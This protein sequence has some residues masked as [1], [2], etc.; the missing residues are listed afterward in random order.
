MLAAATSLRDLNITMFQERPCDLEPEDM[1]LLGG[2]PHLTKLRLG[3][4]D[5]AMPSSMQ[6]WLRALR[7][8]LPQLTVE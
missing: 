3:L 6:R 5:P 7:R 8:R 1:D 4:N 2:L